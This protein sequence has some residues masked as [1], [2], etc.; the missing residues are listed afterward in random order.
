MDRAFFRLCDS[1]APFA[2]R[3]GGTVSDPGIRS[4]VRGIQKSG[5]SLSGAAQPV[6]AVPQSIAVDSL[7]MYFIFFEKKTETK[8][9]MH[10]IGGMYS[11]TN[12]SAV[13]SGSLHTD[14]IC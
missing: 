3:A 6:T 10:G 5:V 13:K 4:A 2:D 1:H 8:L 14:R 11:E 7:P 12:I 9:M